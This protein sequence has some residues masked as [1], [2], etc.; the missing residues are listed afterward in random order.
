MELEK[1]ITCSLL[2]HNLVGYLKEY[3]VKLMQILENL[4]LYHN[5]NCFLVGMHG[6]FD[7]MAQSI[8]WNLKQKY[9]NINYFVVLTSPTMLIKNKQNYCKADNFNETII[10]DIENVYF[11]A[12]IKH[13]VK[14]MV[15]NCQYLVC[16]YDKYRYH[17]VIKY[18]Y[19]YALKL[20][21]QVINLLI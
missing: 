9:P 15:E 14:R 19:N 11:K 12:R 20:N 7:K 4:I 6:S 21:K 18:A 1:Y 17:S 5:V 3:Q 16:Y 10:F 13:S 2:G 8:C